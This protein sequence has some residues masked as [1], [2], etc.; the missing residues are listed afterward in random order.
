MFS[1]WPYVDEI[2]SYKMG[3]F[4]SCNCMESHKSVT[5]FKMN[6][7]WKAYGTQKSTKC[8][9]FGPILMELVTLA[10][11]FDPRLQLRSDST[12][13]L[14]WMCAYRSALRM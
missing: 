10:W 3:P 4:D 9:L 14:A 2:Y 1:I 8:S 12:L 13:Q 11:E 5:P 6:S 7:T